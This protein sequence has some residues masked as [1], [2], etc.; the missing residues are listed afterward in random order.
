MKDAASG[1]VPGRGGQRQVRSHSALGGA[2]AG[3]EVGIEQVG[4]PVRRGYAV[5]SLRAGEQ[6][7]LG[8]VQAHHELAAPRTSACHRHRLGGL[9][10]PR[11]R[12]QVIGR[13]H[14]EI[15]AIPGGRRIAGMV[16]GVADAHVGH[17]CE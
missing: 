3:P 13:C 6:V 4:E 8:G 11:L 1:Q 14:A 5:G 15:G 7:H 2:D 12:A 10:V 9:A 17:E 16:V